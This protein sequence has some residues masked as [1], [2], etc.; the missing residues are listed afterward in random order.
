[1]PQISIKTNFPLTDLQKDKLA[2]DSAD[3]LINELG[4]RD[5]WLSA[6][7]EDNAHIYLRGSHSEHTAVVTLMVYKEIS[8]ESAE[9]FTN[10]M[11]EL[12]TAETDIPS[13][14]VIITFIPVN[15]WGLG[16]KLTE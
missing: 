8:S 9:I 1:M 11:T 13:D 5:K 4:K 3:I 16:G 14:R 6:V 2:K 10:S 7:V 15:Q 12:I